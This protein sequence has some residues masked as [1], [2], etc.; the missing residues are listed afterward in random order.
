MHFQIIPHHLAIIL[1]LSMEED[2]AKLQISLNLQCS[3]I[4]FRFKLTT[5]FTWFH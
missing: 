1:P 5:Y 4:I 2:V 3:M